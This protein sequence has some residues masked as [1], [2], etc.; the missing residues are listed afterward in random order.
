M[1][2]RHRMKTTTVI[3]KNGK[4]DRAAAG[5]G[6]GKRMVIGFSLVCGSVAALLLGGCAVAPYS[7]AYYAPDYGPY[8]SDY[9]YGGDPY[10][11][12]YDPGYY[13]GYAI[14]STRHSR[15]YGSHHFAHDFG[16][17]RTST[18][19]SAPRSAPRSVAPSA[20]RA[21]SRR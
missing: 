17:S 14:G 18:V 6:R 10:Y 13:G 3:S 11:Y 7:T 19:R 12:G 16:T 2:G 9:G 21:P 8:Y 5:I 15:Y 1:K 4:A 20:P